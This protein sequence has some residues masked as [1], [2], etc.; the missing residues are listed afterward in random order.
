[1][2]ASKRF[3][4]QEL[5]IGAISSKMVKQQ[6]KGDTDVDLVFRTLWARPSA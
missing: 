1:M 2:D 4:P 3:G 5:G 6:L